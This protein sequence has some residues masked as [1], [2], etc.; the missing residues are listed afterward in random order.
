VLQASG[1]LQ[2]MIVEAGAVIQS[3]KKKKARK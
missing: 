2:Q 1:E 3:A